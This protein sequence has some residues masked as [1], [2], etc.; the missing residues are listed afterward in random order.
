MEAQA[1]SFES[2]LD[3]TDKKVSQVNKEADR[4]IKMAKKRAAEATEKA[5]RIAHSAEQQKSDAELDIIGGTVSKTKTPVKEVAE[6]KETEDEEQ[7]QF[8]FSNQEKLFRL[9]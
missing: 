3:S 5:E 8:N 9:A 2:Q 4:K 7:V 6:V 1:K